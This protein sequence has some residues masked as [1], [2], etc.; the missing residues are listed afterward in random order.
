MYKVDEKVTENLEPSQSE[1]VN[2]QFQTMEE[3]P[4][5]VE[6]KIENINE[7]LPKMILRSYYQK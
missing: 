2:E 4:P 5:V 1:I 3:K 6:E 7:S